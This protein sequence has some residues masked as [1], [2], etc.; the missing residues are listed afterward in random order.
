MLE[1]SPALCN[2][3]CAQVSRGRVGLQPGANL[4][5]KG[6]K[7]LSVDVSGLNFTE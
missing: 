5:A 4:C 3:Y 6:H 1:H 7:I 2:L